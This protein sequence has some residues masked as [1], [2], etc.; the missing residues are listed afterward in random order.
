M[1]AKGAGDWELLTKYPGDFELLVIGTGELKLLANG[2]GD[3]EL[4]VKGAGD[5]EMLDKARGFID[6]DCLNK[7]TGVSTVM[8][9]EFDSLELMPIGHFDVL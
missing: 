7:G 3:L 9:K 8:V 5:W 2:P 4:I 6:G 1:L